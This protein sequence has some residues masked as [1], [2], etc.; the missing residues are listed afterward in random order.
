MRKGSATIKACAVILGL[1]V[2]WVGCG[3]PKSTRLAGDDPDSVLIQL[4]SRKG[5]TVEETGLLHRYLA[6]VR[7]EAADSPEP[8]HLAGRKVGE[9]IVDQ[10]G[11]EMAHAVAIAEGQNQAATWKERAAAQVRAMN[12]VLG[13]RVIETSSFPDSGE[14]RPVPNLLVRVALANLSAR[15]IDEVEG[16]LRYSD[17]YGRDLFDCSITIREQLPPGETIERVHHGRPV[18]FMDDPGLMWRVRLQDTRVTWDPRLIRF[19]DGTI[20]TVTDE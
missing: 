9:L 16:A 13:V 17:V 8:V 19:T 20:M 2:A 7:M 3:D 10:R 11:W 1:T 15:E 14:D 18:P 4:A 12:G 6:R 5:L